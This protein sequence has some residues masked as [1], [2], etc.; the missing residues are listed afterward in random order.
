M[1]VVNSWNFMFALFSVAFCAIEYSALVH[2]KIAELSDFPETN[3]AEKAVKRAWNIHHVCLFVRRRWRS[4]PCCKY[5]CRSFAKEVRSSDATS[6]ERQG[7]AGDDAARQW[8]MNRAVSS[9]WKLA[10]CLVFGSFFH[11][12]HRHVVIESCFSSCIELLVRVRESEQG[13]PETS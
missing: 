13:K 10:C 2:A 11:L 7:E 1:R 9:E 5:R 3:A 4:L 6:T 8:S 12:L